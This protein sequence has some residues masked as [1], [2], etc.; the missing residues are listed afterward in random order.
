MRTKE[1][2]VVNVNNSSKTTKLGST[3]PV[4]EVEDS[5]TTKGKVST[6]FNLVNQTETEAKLEKIDKNNLF[7]VE[8]NDY[9]CPVRFDSSTLEAS[10]SPLVASGILSEDAKS[11]AI[12]KAKREFLEAHSEEINA[13]QKLTFSEVVEKL[14]K[15]ETLYKKVLSVCNVSE[16]RES[17]YIKNGKVQIFRASQCTDKDGKDRYTDVTLSKEVNGK[18]FTQSLFVEYRD[19][20]TNNILLSIRYGQSRIEAQKRLLNQIAEYNRILSNVQ[21]ATEKAIANGFTK[22]QIIKAVESCF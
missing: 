4:V 2:E 8:V 7:S 5:T 13:S 12:E 22:E 19:I 15:N 3:L 10:L 21:V 18:V 16:L 14:Q 17:D 1:K 9:F 20:T 6:K 11:A